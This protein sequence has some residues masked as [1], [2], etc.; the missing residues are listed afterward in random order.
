MDEVQS[1]KPRRVRAKPR[2]AEVV[3][4]EQLTP[5]MVRLVF[6]GEELDGFT[7]KG[8]A[9]HLKV[10]F[11]TYGESKVVLPAWGAEGPILSEGQQRPVNRTYTPRRWE[12]AAKELTVDFLLHDEGPGSAWAQQAQPGQ[13]VAV[14][15]Q[16][17][18]AYKVENEADWYLIGGD[19]AA[20]PAI[21]TL[22]E[23]LPASCFA[24]VFVEVADADEELTLESS[25]RFQVTW[26]HH[27]R[28]I[29]QVGRK[30][31]QA[32]RQFSFLEGSGRVWIGCEAGVMRDIRR[33]LLNERGM[34]RAHA[35]TQGYWKS[36]AVNHPDN[37][38][39][40]DVG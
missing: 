39:G 36:G 24:H 28:A 29:G 34:D 22:L 20:L 13:V 23:S 18:G 15:N 38:R 1:P 35:H 7:T 9:E 32:L 11:P 19:E 33:H 21:G 5:R 25:A 14:S 4:V 30:L 6:S 10:N 31:E 27:D 37:D 17:G 16:P 40:Q 8:P 12:P 26:L 2:L 3:R